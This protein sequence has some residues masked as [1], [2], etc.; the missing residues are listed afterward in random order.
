[1]DCNSKI[2][3]GTSGWS[4]KHWTGL[5]Y[6]KQVKIKEYLSF[7]AQE[8]CTAEINN[9]FY[10][11]P[12]ETTLLNWI[13]MVPDHFKFCPKM[14]RYLSHMKKLHDAT[15]PVERFC[16]LFDAIKERLGPV[17]IQLPAGFHFHPELTEEFYQILETKN[18]FRFAME[19]R[20]ESWLSDESI[21]LMKRYQIC[22]VF[23][24]SDQFP[25]HEEIT[26]KDIYVRLHGPSQLYASSYDDNYLTDFARKLKRWRS[27]G[28]EIWVYFNNDVHGY[29]IANA[30][31]TLELIK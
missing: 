24:D 22:L 1:M 3:V 20:H 18:D 4:Y 12:K 25:Y 10:R 7:Y 28:H 8:F 19:V 13:T 14:S 23:A 6:P 9:S 21:R 5:Y 29:A 17:L 16:S 31:R 2:H 30:R 11:L 27:D 26:T 15:E